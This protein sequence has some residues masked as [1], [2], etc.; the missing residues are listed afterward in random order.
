MPRLSI[1]QIRRKELSEA[2]YEA[3][4]IWGLPGTTLVRVA[5]KAGVSKGIVLHYFRNKDE[6]I[7]AAMRRANA[8]LRDEVVRRLDQARSPRER[9]AAVIEGNFDEQFFVPQITHA[10][11]SFC[12][13]VPRNPQFARLQ[14]AIHA[15]MHSNLM[16]ALRHLLPRADAEEAARAISIMIDGLWLRHGLVQGG[17]DRAGALKHM[18]ALVDSLLTSR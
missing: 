1:E 14:R 18:K 16:S 13:E 4:Q 12:G 7:E 2:A 10:W 17:I 3:L 15:R 6:L 8:A 11:L 9:L 5:A